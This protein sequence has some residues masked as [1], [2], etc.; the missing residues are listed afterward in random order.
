LTS[1][2]TSLFV[3]RDF[4]T[5]NVTFVVKP[6]E[7]FQAARP[8]LTAA[9]FLIGVGGHNLDRRRLVPAAFDIGVN[10]RPTS[11]D[12]AT[13]YST[14]LL[15]TPSILPAGSLRETL[16]NILG[17]HVELI[18]ADLSAF[19][20]LEFCA[21]RRAPSTSTR[22]RPAWITKLTKML[23]LISAYKCCQSAPAQALVALAN[24][25]QILLLQERGPKTLQV[26]RFKCRT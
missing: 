17:R 7:D 18:E 26:Q 4:Q 15:R 22:I 8:I 21:P 13:I 16:Q 11:T 23:C 6:S 19:L 24:R 14:H 9:M 3:L 10:E 1:R 20:A 2:T 25:P 12:A 5:R